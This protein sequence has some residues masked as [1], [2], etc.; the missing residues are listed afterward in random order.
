M[1]TI[2]IEGIDGSGKSTFVNKLSSKNNFEIIVQGNKEEYLKLDINS[3]I[4]FLKK[5]FLENVNKNVIFDRFH[6]S[7]FVYSRTLRNQNINLN[8]IERR[9][10]GEYINNV[11]LVLVDI[12]PAI[13]QERIK[14][15][16]GKYYN[17]NLF[18]ERELF[19]TAYNITNIPKKIKFYNDREVI[20]E[21]ITNFFA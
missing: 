15:R 8:E 3:K 14:I 11:I 7:E 17:Q 6:I 21:V 4:E 9:I 2:I 13:A 12:D 5:M 16:D 19:F 10:F 1:N 20:D 18:K